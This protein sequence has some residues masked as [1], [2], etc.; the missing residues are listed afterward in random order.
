MYDRLIVDEKKVD[1]M[2]VAIE[3][4]LQQEDPVGKIKSEQVLGKWIEN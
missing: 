1:G 4:V 2:I 3:E